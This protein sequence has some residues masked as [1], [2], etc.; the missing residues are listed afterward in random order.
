VT[1]FF[2]RSTVALLLATQL[3]GAGAPDANQPTRLPEIVVTG[4]RSAVELGA[5][6]LFR[7]LPPRDLRKQLLAE[8]PGLDAATSLLGAEEIRWRNTPLLLDAMSHVPGAWMETRGRKEK[9]LFSVRGQRY[10]YPDFLLDGAW[11]RS[12]T[13]TAFHFSSANLGQIQILRSSA[14]LLLTPESLGGAV[15]LA[16]RDPRG[17]EFQVDAAGGT[18]GTFRSHVNHGEGG[19]RFGGAWG[20]GYVRTDGPAGR[21]ARERVADWYARVRIQPTGALTLGVSAFAL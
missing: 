8:S 12:F 20:A 10:P 3:T 13:E 18:H 9:Q 14:G 21:N 17:R 16:P 1:H 2:R 19:D 6:S 11:F 4:E 5:D 15:E 7:G